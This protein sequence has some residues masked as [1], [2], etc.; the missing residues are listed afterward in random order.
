MH[1]M[2]TARRAGLAF[3][4][5]SVVEAFGEQ[6]ASGTATSQLVTPSIA[7]V[8]QLPRLSVESRFAHLLDRLVVR[9][10]CVESD[11]GQ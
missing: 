5:L 4:G 7:L 2:S 10:T 9:R 11:S 8:K 3:L 1:F 6:P